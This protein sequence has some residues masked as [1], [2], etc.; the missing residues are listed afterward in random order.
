MRT[1]PE[2]A[3]LSDEYSV[4]FVAM[5]VCAGQ[6]KCKQQVES[7]RD[8]LQ[9]FVSWRPKQNEQMLVYDSF[10]LLVHGGEDVA[11][12]TLPLSWEQADR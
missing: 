9:S 8:P 11:D 6:L 12:K 1:S 7:T 3:G 2:D 4:L 10:P 5:M